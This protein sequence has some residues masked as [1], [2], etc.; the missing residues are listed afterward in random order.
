MYP[1]SS[2]SLIAPE[3]PDGRMLAADWAEGMIDA[4]VLRV[5]AWD[6]PFEDENGRLLIGPIMTQLHDK[7]G[8]PF[9]DR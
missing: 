9:E 6:A 4:F 5:D 8:K 2:W 1:A 3:A 7:D